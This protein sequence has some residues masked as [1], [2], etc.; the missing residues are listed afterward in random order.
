MRGE[1]CRRRRNSISDTVKNA[2]PKRYADQDGEVEDTGE[3]WFGQARRDRPPLPEETRKRQVNLMLDP[4]VVDQL[5]A[6]DGMSGRVSNLLR[7]ELG[8]G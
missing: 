3:A 2:D 7:R 1:Q 6:E 5:R 8:L 4:K